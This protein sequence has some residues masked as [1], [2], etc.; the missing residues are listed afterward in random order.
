MHVGVQS[1]LEG[2]VSWDAAFLQSGRQDS[3]CNRLRV[4]GDKGHAG[5]GRASG[6]R[7]SEVGRSGVG[8]MGGLTGV[9]ERRLREA[10]GRAGEDVAGAVRR[11]GQD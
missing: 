1:I 5:G 8:G 2:G 3:F 10:G 9:E 11:E 6:G 4:E 7:F